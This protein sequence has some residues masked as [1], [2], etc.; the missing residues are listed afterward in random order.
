M[1]KTTNY[2]LTLWDYADEDFSPGRARADLAANFTKLDTAL[3]AEETAR[4]AAVTAEVN[5]RKSAVAERA[6]V[7]TGSYTGNSNTE[8]N[9]ARTINLG[10][11][12]K[13][14]MLVNSEGRMGWSGNSEMGAGGLALP[15]KP[16]TVS[17]AT[18][19][20]IVTGGFQVKH[21]SSFIT[22]NR[23]STSY[24]YLVLR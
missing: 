12:P 10:F 23:A 16:V 19:L 7:V 9:Q 20:E 2:Q 13:A 22:T 21:Q 11:T 18:I 15:G 6:L 3:K 14:V 5:A 17:S 1:S 8:G 4:A 24:Y